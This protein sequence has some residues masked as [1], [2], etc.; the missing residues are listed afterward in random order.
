MTARVPGDG[1]PLNLTES[2][3]E[4]SLDS[5]VASGGPVRAQVNP[6]RTRTPS[7]S[8]ALADSGSGPPAGGGARRARWWY[9]DGVPGPLRL[10]LT[11]SRTLS[12]RLIP[13]G[14]P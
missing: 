3:S 14:P 6:A 1:D 7:L 8:E 11:L 9:R 5:E 4:S 13:A 12:G 10:T 2:A